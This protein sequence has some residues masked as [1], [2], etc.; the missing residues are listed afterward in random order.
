MKTLLEKVSDM[1]IQL[2]LRDDGM[3]KM[4]ESIK[5]MELNVSN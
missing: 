2:K 1:E 4:H 5:D 3:Q